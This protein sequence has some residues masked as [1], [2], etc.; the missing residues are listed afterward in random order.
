[1][2]NEPAIPNVESMIKSNLQAGLT[3]E[4]RQKLAK[5]DNFDWTLVSHRLMR[6]PVAVFLVWL[7]MPF[8]RKFR[9][10]A[11]SRYVRE[12]IASF[13]QW[14]AVA[15]V[16][17]QG[18][19]AISKE[20]DDFGW[21]PIQL[22]S[23]E[24]RELC[25]ATLGTHLDHAPFLAGRKEGEAEQLVALYRQTAE[26]I[27]RWFD[28]VDHHFV[29]HYISIADVICKCRAVPAQQQMVFA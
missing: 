12:A 9:W 4:Q 21:H 27:R 7:Q 14:Y 18:E 20:L 16:L 13:K 17:S 6:S 22:F 3:Y 28:A 1:M 29:P 23:A 24:Y 8:S 25:F 5:I 2:Q 11:V 26:E 10:N 15:T 19:W